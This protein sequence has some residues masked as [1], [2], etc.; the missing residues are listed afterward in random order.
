MGLAES[1]KGEGCVNYFQYLVRDTAREIRLEP[2]SL[3]RDVA[4][5][6]RSSLHAYFDIC[7]RSDCGL[8]RNPNVNQRDLARDCET[9]RGAI[10][11]STL[12]QEYIN[13]D[14]TCGGSFNEA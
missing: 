3:L 9:F 4:D 2:D 11:R 7:Q 10:R 1:K 14:P 8:W 13:K 5:G 12:L 6:K